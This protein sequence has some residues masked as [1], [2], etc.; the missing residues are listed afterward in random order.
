MNQGPSK[1]PFGRRR[2]ALWPPVPVSAAATIAVFTWVPHWSRALEA[3]SLVAAVTGVA[4]LIA[5]QAGKWVRHK[6]GQR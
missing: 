3:A 5:P 1:E 2:F 4:W 6:L